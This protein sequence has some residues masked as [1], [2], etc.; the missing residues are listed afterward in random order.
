MIRTKGIVHFSLAVSDIARSARFFEEILG[1]EVME[2][3]R[4][5]EEIAGTLPVEDLR[6]SWLIFSDGFSRGPVRGVSKRLFDLSAASV[7]LLLGAP[8]MI[9]AALAVRSVQPH[10]RVLG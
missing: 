4:V 9:I 7:G 8:V 6:P 10:R 3:P 2:E 5:H 1:V